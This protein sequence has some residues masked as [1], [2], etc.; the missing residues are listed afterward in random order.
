MCDVVVPEC[1]ATVVYFLKAADAALRK[2]SF[3]I[4]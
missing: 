1:G 4:V 2:A 3:N